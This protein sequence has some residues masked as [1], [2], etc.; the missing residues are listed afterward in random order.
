MGTMV[1]MDQFT[2]RSGGLKE[3]LLAALWGGIDIILIPEQNR[4]ELVEI[5]S[6]IK[7]NLDIRPVQCGSTRYGS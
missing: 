4:R 2:S 3:K 6:N 5:P 1:V 7:Q